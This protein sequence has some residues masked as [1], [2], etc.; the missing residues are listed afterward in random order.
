MSSNQF[1]KNHPFLASMKDRYSLSKT[2]SKKNTFHIVLDVGNSGLTYEVGDSVGIYPHYDDKLVSKTLHALGMTGEE[3]VVTK[4]N[5]NIDLKYFLKFR[6]N[7]SEVTPRLFRAMLEKIPS[8]E[9]QEELKQL[10]EDENRE[11]YKAYVQKFEVWDFILAYPKMEWNPQE[12][13][14]TL[15]PLLP[16]FYSISS[17]QK[18]VGNEIHLTIAPLEFVSNGHVRYGVC[19]HYLMNLVELNDPV[20]PIFIQ[21]AHS[22]RLPLDPHAHPLI[23]IGP[24]TGI[25]PFR[26]FMQE[27][28]FHHKSKAKH[29]LFFGEW[30]QEYDFLYEQEWIEFEKHGHIQLDA[31]F[32]RDQEEKIYVQH[33]MWEKGAEFYR[34][35][36]EG[37][38][39]YICGDAKKMAK[40]VENELL[41]IIQVYGE[42][43]KKEAL[44]YIKE[45]RK[46]K[47]YLRDV[48]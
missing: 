40:D 22:F 14:D 9:R 35:L 37:A 24:G 41:R 48:Y 11:Q 23:M 15:M 26:A 30:N 16:R 3:R 5:E 38:I 25:A 33:R 12:F 42:K 2:G 27:R 17:S 32:S 20:I 13:I 34:W 28:L 21:P 43:D 36:E 4:E 7:L 6:A 31:V 45:L 39:L 18:Y 8:K 10:L 1:D 44:D 29:W 47:R 19:T 46:N